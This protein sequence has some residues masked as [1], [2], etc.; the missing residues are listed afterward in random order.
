MLHF[1]QHDKCGGILHA[2]FV[3]PNTFFC[4]SERKRGIYCMDASLRYAAFSMTKVKHGCFAS[5]SM[6]RVGMSFR[7]RA[8]NP[9]CGDLLFLSFCK[10]RR[11]SSAETG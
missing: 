7:A 9:A 1:V 10:G 6:T 3:I 4:H 5:F 2:L 8:R 11:F